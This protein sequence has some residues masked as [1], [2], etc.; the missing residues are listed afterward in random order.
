[1]L[2]LVAMLALASKNIIRH[3]SKS[4]TIY[5]WITQWHIGR[6]Y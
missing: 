4:N 6:F 1:M 3:A 5:F 2:E